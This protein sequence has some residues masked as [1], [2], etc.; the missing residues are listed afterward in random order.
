MNKTKPL[1]IVLAAILI[2]LISEIVFVSTHPDVS[3]GYI[4]KAAK[5]ISGVGKTDLA[6][7]VLTKGQVKLPVNHS[8]Q[9]LVKKYLLSV[10]LEHNLARVYYDL[11]LL[12]YVN[13]EDGLTSALLELSIKTDPDFSF[14]YVELANYYLLKDQN[15]K[16]K[17][18][19]DTCLSRIGPKRHCEDYLL[20]SFNAGL[21]KNVGFLRKAIDD[22]FASRFR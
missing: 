14:W 21:F 4:L 15:E 9:N 3:S 12:S 18:I 11:A 2:L 6:F 10:P 8:Y 20:D 22:Y 13:N 5:I 17:R 7:S 19:L 1:L 16:G